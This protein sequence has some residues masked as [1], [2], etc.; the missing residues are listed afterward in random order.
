MPLAHRRRLQ[1]AP[2]RNIDD[3]VERVDMSHW[4]D[5]TVSV[6]K[7]ALADRG[8]K[9]TGKKDELIERLVGYEENDDFK[10]PRVVLP[11]ADPMPEFPPTAF[12][13]PLTSVQHPILTSPCATYM[14]KGLISSGLSGNTTTSRSQSTIT[15]YA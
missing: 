13:S 11:E 14:M 10:G 8:A 7:Q 5:K 1:A 4:K 3:F 6:I 2:R 15:R 9:T 12:F